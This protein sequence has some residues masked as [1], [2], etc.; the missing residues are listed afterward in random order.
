MTRELVVAEK[1]AAD[2]DLL[3]FLD[4]DDARVVAPPGPRL[5]LFLISI[6]KSGTHLL[7][8]LARALGYRDGVVCPDA[9]APGTWY[10]LEY[11]NSHT[12][13]ADFL[14][15]T[16]RRRFRQ[17]APSVLPF[18]GAV[19]LPQPARRPRLRVELV[20]Q[21]EEQPARGV[22][23]LARAGGAAV[24]PGRGPLAAR[25]PP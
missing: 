24:A 20:P 15:D 10:C 21:G 4:R 14:V 6:P 13:A 18:A 3:A 16:T 9:P 2:G 22:L 12:R 7:Y 19:H 17:Q 23:E 25:L 1:Q 8:E 11:S 5:P